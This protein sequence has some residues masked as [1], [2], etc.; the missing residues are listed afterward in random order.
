MSVDEGKKKSGSTTMII[1]FFK[2][3]NI[4]N[5]AYKVETIITQLPKSHALPVEFVT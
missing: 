2:K 3:D 5:N 1:V 4:M